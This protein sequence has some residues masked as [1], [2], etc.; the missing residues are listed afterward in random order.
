MEAAHL[1]WD[2]VNDDISFF[3][4]AY[5]GCIEDM[6]LHEINEEPFKEF[7]GKEGV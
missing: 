3:I 6:Y 2:Y 1:L 4:M 5:M 7:Y